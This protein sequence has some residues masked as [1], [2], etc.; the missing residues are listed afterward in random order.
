MR[1]ITLTID[2]TELDPLVF[3]ERL[4]NFVLHHLDGTVT[5]QDVDYYHECGVNVAVDGVR[6]F[7]QV[8][9]EY[10]AMQPLWETVNT[11]RGWRENEL[12][13]LKA[14]WFALAEE[15]A[16]TAIH[17]VEQGQRAE[18]LGQWPMDE[19]LHAVWAL[20]VAM[21]ERGAD[22]DVWFG[23]DFARVKAMLA[24]RGLNVNTDRSDDGSRS[25]VK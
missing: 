10:R 9:P 1:K 20:T 18:V 16:M 22:T 6:A 23:Q 4:A 19:F 13:G 15:A 7:D 17:R 5:K 24:V 11:I 12:I 14:R 21:H 3:D 2:E 25:P 8:S